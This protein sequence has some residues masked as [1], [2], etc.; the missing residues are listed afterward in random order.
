MKLFG[1]I[2][3]W[4]LRGVA[5]TFAM[6]ALAL[7]AAIPA[8]FMISV[9]DGAPRLIPCVGELP[10]APSSGSHL[11][12]GVEMTGIAVASAPHDHK[13]DPDG[14]KNDGSRSHSECVF[15]GHG[16]GAPAPSLIAESTEALTLYT[17][18]T[19]SAA[20]RDIIP[21]RGL[22]A[23]PPPARGPPTI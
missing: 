6:M 12:T 15:A 20:W 3:G 17:A 1:M 11:T 4:R 9:E 13:D 2:K 16:A 10:G 19:P 14:R 7:R 8:G 23:P 5:V 21:G 22:S 18:E